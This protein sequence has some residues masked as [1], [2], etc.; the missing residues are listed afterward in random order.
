MKRFILTALT[1]S[2]LAGCASFPDDYQDEIGVP[3]IVE[4]FADAWSHEVPIQY[5]QSASGASISK[6]FTLP[7]DVASQEVS[8]DFSYGVSATVNDLIYALRVQ[9]YKVVSRLNGAESEELILRKFS[10]NLGDFVEA[11]SHTQNIA[12]EYR[13]GVLFVLEANRYSVS[14]P[15]HEALLAQVS[16]SLTEMGATAV[17]TDLLAGMVHFDAKPDISDYITE[18][19]DR[20]AQNSAMINLQIAVVTVG[21]NR[22]LNVGFDWAALMATTGTKNLRPGVAGR[23]ASEG[24][25]T[26]NDYSI[27]QALSFAGG[28][29]LGYVFNSNSFSLSTAIKAL[30]TYGDARTEQ[31]VVLGT[32]S[33]MPVSISSGNDIPYVKSIGSTTASGGSTSGST[34]T[35][36]IRSGLDLSITPNFDSA[37]NAVVTTIKVKMSSLV[38]FRELQAGNNL[39]TLSQ[40]EMQNLDFENV[41]RLQAGETIVVGGITYD[42][43]SNNYNNLPGLERLPTGSK[44]EMVNKNAIYI[45]VRPTVVIFSREADRLNA[46]LARGAVQGGGA[47]QW[48]SDLI[49]Y[50]NGVTGGLEV[51]HVQDPRHNIP[52]HRLGTSKSKWS[53]K[54]VASVEFSED[55]TLPP[56][57]VEAMPVTEPSIRIKEIIGE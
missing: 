40:P 28:S 41:G 1:A 21:L 49:K 18:Y 27:G 10:G 33:G 3:D 19:L 42:Q 51:R 8:L 4:Q 25:T 20:I 56:Q 22:D 36:I 37:D 45:V 38:G 5:V 6:Y 23:S 46:E 30:S 43:L 14:L 50:N 11:L 48:S 26:T 47:S 9:G 32:V 44:A 16:T 29:G 35:E 55:L 53:N 54:D 31:N 12:Y 13:N 34:Q 24:N 39:G 15:Q 57:V 2:I 17:R 52:P 7:E